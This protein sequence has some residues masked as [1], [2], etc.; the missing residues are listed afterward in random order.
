MRL[1]DLLQGPALPIAV[2][3]GQYLLQ[4]QHLSAGN[5]VA[6]SFTT[7]KSAVVRASELIRAGYAIEICSSPS[8]E[9]RLVG[10]S[11][12]KS[13][14]L[15]WRCLPA[16]RGSVR[17]RS[18]FRR[19]RTNRVGLLALPCSA[20]WRACINHLGIVWGEMSDAT[21]TFFI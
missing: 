15:G 16:P 19:S 20:G 8:L 11:A 14:Q 7:F 13:G 6:E 3:Q 1:S 21:Q 12:L 2:A 17:T 5:A 18:A 4:G 10:D 9:R